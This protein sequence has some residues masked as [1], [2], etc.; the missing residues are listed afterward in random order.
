MNETNKKLKVLIENNEDLEW[1]PTTDEI[2][3]AMNKDLHILFTKRNLADYTRDRRNP[4]FSYNRNYDREKKKENLHYFIKTFLDVGAGDGRVFSAVKGVNGDI[5]ID[6]KYGIEIAQTQADGLIKNDVFLIGRDFFKTTLID[7][8]YSVIFSNPPFSVYSLWVEKLIEEA[9]FGVMYLVIP[10]RW[11]NSIGKNPI[12]KTYEVVKVGEF[13]F[14]HADRTAR[15]K[16]NLIRINPKPIKVSEYYHGEDVGNHIEYG[17]EDDPDSFE[18]WMDKHF[19]RFEQEDSEQ[20]EAKDVKLK[21]GTVD[22]L[23]ESYDYEMATL[24]DSFKA[25]GK[26]PFRVIDALGMNRSSILEI[27]RENIKSLKNR[28]WRLAFDRASA[29]N[30]RLIQKTREKLLNQME[31]YSTLDFNKENL[32][33]IIVWVVKHFNEYTGEQILSVFDALTR[34]DYIKAYKS[35]VHWTKD[36]WRYADGK[37]KP[38]KY[39]LDYRLVTHCYKRYL[40]DQNT[41]DDFIVVCRSLGFYIHEGKSLNPEA[42]GSEQRF[43]TVTG[44]HAFTARLYKNHNAHLKVNQKLMMKFNIEVGRLRHWI[45]NHKDIENEFDVTP[46]EA[47]KLWN[48]PS[49]CLLGNNDIKLLEF[50]SQREEK[51]A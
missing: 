43:Y 17:K 48:N 3:S 44:E 24:L 31:E 38:E 6:R 46:I 27:L 21:H 14:S 50:D 10:E 39:Q 47:F 45:N 40:Y 51:S 5:S 36:D 30:S 20:E 25:L 35:N 23:I 9:N 42:I 2:L 49:L 29:I 16:V 12:L 7:K 13:D 1:Y 19:G 22:D 26:M 8:K 15:G 37:G 32:Y 18:R 4:F 34:Q 11:E 28:Y 33:S 41:V